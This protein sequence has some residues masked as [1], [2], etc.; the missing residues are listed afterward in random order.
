FSLYKSGTESDMVKDAAASNG[1]AASVIGTCKEWSIMAN[2]GKFLDA[3]TYTWQ[4]SAMVR[5]DAKADA[6]QTD[7]GVDCGIYDSPNRKAICEM[8]VPVKDF[9]GST[10]QRIDLGAHKLSGEICIWFMPTQNPAVTKVYVDRI[11][12]IREK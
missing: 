12:L 1:K 2:L 9:A 10:Y 5:I 11:I 8:T 6:P 3:S 4:V 7:A